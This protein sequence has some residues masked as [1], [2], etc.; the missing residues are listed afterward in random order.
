MTCGCLNDRRKFMI[1]LQQ[2]VLF[3]IVAN[4]T[5]ADMLFK[6][7][8]GV[9]RLLLQTVIFLAITFLLMKY[10]KK[11]YIKNLH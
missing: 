3:F 1:S 4:P 11:P 2:A 5:I 10:E 6:D 8:T 9:S 7:I